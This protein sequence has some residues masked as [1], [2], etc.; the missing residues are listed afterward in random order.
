MNELVILFTGILISCKKIPRV[1]IYIYIYD[2]VYKHIHIYIRIYVCVYCF[3]FI[4]PKWK[5]N[6]TTP[7]RRTAA[8]EIVAS[9][10]KHVG[11]ILLL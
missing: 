10:G 7:I 5:K 8:R 2:I 3:L 6:K 9:I 4:T 1:Y 11:P